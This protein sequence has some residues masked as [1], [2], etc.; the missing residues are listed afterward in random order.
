[1]SY[2]ATLTEVKAALVDVIKSINTG[3]G[4]G[5]DIPEEHVFPHYVSTSNDS[6]FPRVFVVL[7]SGDTQL[8]PNFGQKRSIRFLVY[9]IVKALE[10]HQAPTAM[11]EQ[12]LVDIEQAI[13]QNGSLNGTVDSAELLEFITDGG[14]LNPEG[15]AILV[16]EALQ[17]HDR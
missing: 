7:D 13:Y 14:V 8:R 2:R 3:N 15:A 6:L 9:V 4:Y 11:I 12:L 5:T 17:A 10:D 16:I 1:M